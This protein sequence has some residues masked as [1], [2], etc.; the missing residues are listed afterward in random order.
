[1]P[2]FININYENECNYFMYL[3]KFRSGEHFIPCV[4]LGLGEYIDK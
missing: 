3:V 1:M 2:Y 4:V